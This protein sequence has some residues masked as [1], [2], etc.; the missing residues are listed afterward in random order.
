MEIWHG[1][2][3]VRFRPGPQ[4]SVGDMMA[5]VEEEVSG[6]IDRTGN[7]HLKNWEIID[8]YHFGGYAK[9]SE[10]LIRFINE[11][12]KEHKVPLDPVYTGKM[13]YGINQEIQEGSI[14]KNTRIL[15]VHTGGL[16][17]IAGMNERLK[18]MNLPLIETDE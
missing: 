5:P 14:P 16:Q 8:D 9:Y 13:M 10:E 4:P 7:S 6:L 2:V 1:F 3:F 15:A 18:R 17:G 12:R 11:F